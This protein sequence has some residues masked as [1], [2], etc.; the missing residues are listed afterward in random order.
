MILVIPFINDVSA[1]KNIS[2][3]MRIWIDVP[4]QNLLISPVEQE[5]R[6]EGHAAYSGTIDHISIIINDSE[7]TTIE[8]LD[9]SG[10]LK[11]FET[12]WTPDEAGEYVIK[13][14]AF[15]SDNEE[16]NDTVKVK[17]ADLD[18]EEDAATQPEG[19]QQDDNGEEINDD[20]EATINFWADSYNVEAGSCTSLHWETGNAKSVY[21]DGSQVEASGSSQTCLCS[22]EIHTL[23]VENLDSTYTEESLTINVIGSCEQPEEEVDTVNPPKVTIKEPKDEEDLS[24]SSE[25]SLKWYTVS[26]PSGISEYRVQVQSHWGDYSWQDHA[27]SPWEGITGTQLDIGTECAVYYRFRVRAVDGAGNEGAYSDWEEFQVSLM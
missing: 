7:L 13:A 2:W 16:S 3:P 4:V 21:L 9:S 20:E 12:F 5:V 15:S 19:E 18:I 23:K 11:H 8:N 25:V 10:S 27:D 1:G 26:D 14:T 24:C 22:Q 6:I 17:V